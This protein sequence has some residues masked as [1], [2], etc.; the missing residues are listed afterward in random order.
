MDSTQ[1]GWWRRHG[2]TLAL[3]LSAFGFTLLINTVWQYPIIAQ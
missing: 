1:V 2:W 3:L